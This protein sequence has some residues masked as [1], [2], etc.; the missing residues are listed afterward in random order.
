LHAL[1]VGAP[2]NF[3]SR[4]RLLSTDELVRRCARLRR[5]PRE[6]LEHQVTSQALRSVARRAEMLR[7]EAASNEQELARLVHELAPGLEAQQGVGPICAAQIICAWS[8]RGRVRSEA[9][10]AA[11]AGVAPIPASSGQIVRHR[12]NRGGDRQLNR[13]LHTVVLWRMHH[14]S[15]GAVAASS[16]LGVPGRFHPRRRRASRLG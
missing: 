3:R 1:V 7:A 11:L 5:H 9:A 6:C 4:L 12:L 10:F 15:D 8:H 16:A 13:A 2:E 14:H